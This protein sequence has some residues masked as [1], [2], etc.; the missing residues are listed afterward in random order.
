MADT[1]QFLEEVVTNVKQF[2]AVLEP[3][4]NAIGDVR[5]SSISAG[6]THLGAVSGSSVMLDVELALDTN[7]VPPG[8]V[9]VE[10]VE[11]VDATR[12]ESGCGVVQSIELSSDL[13]GALD[14]VLFSE[15][16]ELGAVG[17]KV[18]LGASDALKKLGVVEIV[19]SDYVSL[20][21][22]Q[23]VTIPNI[24]IGLKSAPDSRSLWIGAVARDVNIGF[25]K[26]L[27]IRLYI[28]LD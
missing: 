18:N 2:H 1:N 15:C 28:L 4:T 10:P 24:G 17:E 26:W 25:A 16:V 19:G 13:A 12:T 27:N 6:E 3:S 14:L 11:L 20:G 5:V 7:R 21:S 23:S 8:G 22:C 9:L